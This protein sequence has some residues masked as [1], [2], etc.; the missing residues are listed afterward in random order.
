MSIINSLK[1]VFQR[2]KAKP[3]SSLTGLPIIARYLEIIDKLAESLENN[4]D[5]NQ[6]GHIA[7]SMIGAKNRMELAKSFY[8]RMAK[9]FEQIF[10]T[11][12]AAS[13]PKLVQDLSNL[14]SGVMQSALWG[15]G[16]V[17]PDFELERIASM[18]RGTSE[19]N[20]ENMRLFDLN[21]AELKEKKGLSKAETLDSF[22]DFLWSLNPSYV[23]YWPLV[24]LRIGLHYPDAGN[25]YRYAA[26][27]EGCADSQYVLGL[28]YEGDATMKSTL[29]EDIAL[30]YEESAKWFLMAAE[31]GLAG[32]QLKLGL[33]YK[34]GKG[35]TINATESAKWLRQAADQ[36]LAQAQMYL[37]IAYLSGYG[38]PLDAEEALK[39]LLRAA[40]QGYSSAQLS[41]GLYYLCYKS[42][43]NHLVLSYMWSYI[44]AANG[45]VN[46]PT[47]VETASRKMTPE[48]ITEAQRLAREWKPT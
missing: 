33:A 17:L 39:W 40:N 10:K 26:S 25:L 14:L 18:K 12:D 1:S 43:P 44:S 47:Q 13:L 19:Y 34:D 45:E 7:L 9:D 48:Q 2:G 30:N 21:M 28:A 29:S 31:Q 46:G 42:I 3:K 24:L 20:A 36:G 8:I 22:V 41:L 16:A 32:A 23:S 11:K 37:A 38:L 5:V 35:V 27:V 6:S 15:F 4:L